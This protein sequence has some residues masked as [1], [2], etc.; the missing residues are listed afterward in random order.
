MKAIFT[1]IDIIN[2]Y[3]HNVT[4]LQERYCSIDDHIADIASTTMRFI[5]MEIK[6]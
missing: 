2:I 6:R 4:I 1:V 3:L 5:K